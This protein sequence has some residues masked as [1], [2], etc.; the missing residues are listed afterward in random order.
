MA[1]ISQPLLVNKFMINF[2]VKMN[3]LNITSNCFDNMTSFSIKSKKNNDKT[4]TINNEDKQKN[5]SI[6]IKGEN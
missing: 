2:N 4:I 6:S 3:N 1:E 5:K